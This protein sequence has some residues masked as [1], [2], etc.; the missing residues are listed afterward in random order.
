MPII[1]MKKILK[2]IK[3]VFVALFITYT[4]NVVSAAYVSK[5]GVVDP[6]GNITP[7]NTG[8][9]VQNILGPLSI[10]STSMVG[11]GVMGNG[12]NAQTVKLYVFGNSYFKKLN[13]MEGEI[14]QTGSITADSLYLT[15][16]RN[17]FQV[18]TGGGSTSGGSSSTIYIDQS[19]CV[20]AN[21]EVVICS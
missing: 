14:Y 10:G 19:L 2:N 16:P 12:T 17:L 5:P 3:F 1:Y 13:V 20:D 21:R 6:A 18:S 4:I 7:I 15:N 9:Q 8:N 11:G